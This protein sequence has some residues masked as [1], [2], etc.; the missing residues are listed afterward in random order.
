MGAGKVTSIPSL[1]LTNNEQHLV[2]K[3]KHEQLIDPDHTLLW[4]GCRKCLNRKESE[5]YCELE[6]DGFSI[7]ETLGGKHPFLRPEAQ[8]NAD[9]IDA[10]AD[11]GDFV[12]GSPIIVN[13]QVLTMSGFLAN[14]ICP[15]RY[16]AQEY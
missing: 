16:L 8:I 15:P 5:P 4:E 10:K 6:L 14:E 12:L 9:V 3:L 11:D 1:P 2:H 7:P 13:T